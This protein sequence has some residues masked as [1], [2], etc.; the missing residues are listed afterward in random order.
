VNALF[1]G[2]IAG[3]VTPARC[4]VK[5]ALLA[6]YWLAAPKMQTASLPLFEA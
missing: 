2:V 3:S 1:A 4:L 6:P 5:F